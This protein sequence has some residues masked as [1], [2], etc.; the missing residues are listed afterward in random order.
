[1]MELRSIRCR[2]LVDR[3]KGIRCDVD[4][5]RGELGVVREL[6]VALMLM[7][8]LLPKAIRGVGGGSGHDLMPSQIRDGVWITR[9]RE[10]FQSDDI[11]G[12]PRDR[13][14][15]ASGFRLVCQ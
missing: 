15:Q 13:Y 14:Q 7:G 3:R 6:D 1:M 9:P 5:V 12:C 8:F 10:T 4:M 2:Y 11:C